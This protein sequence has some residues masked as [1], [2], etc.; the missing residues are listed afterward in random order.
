[1]N[2]Y[3]DYTV[4]HLRTRPIA[5]HSTNPALD[6]LNNVSGTSD[7]EVVLI[8]APSSQTQT[9]RI[10]NLTLIVNKACRVK[11]QAFR[12]SSTVDLTGYIPLVE[13]AGFVIASP[14]S[15]FVLP[16]GYGL[17][18]LVRGFVEDSNAPLTNDLRLGGFLTEVLG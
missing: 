2:R 6:R 12:G 7:Q 18:L 16:A 8:P 3:H 14:E 17:R 13:G 15:S 5:I 9:L 1:M 10:A 4:S 11:F